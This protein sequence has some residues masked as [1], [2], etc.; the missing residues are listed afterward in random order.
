MTAND[1]LT[2][3]TYAEEIGSIENRALYCTMFPMF[4]EHGLTLTP[5]LFWKS[6]ETTYLNLAGAEGHTAIVR[7]IATR[8][9]I[10][11]FGGGFLY[12]HEFQFFDM[13]SYVA[14]I[15]S[16]FWFI[17]IQ[18]SEMTSKTYIINAPHPHC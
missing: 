2:M 11:K 5:D 9:L 8:R 10:E 4:L 7:D 14:S 17:D 16:E 6:I 12:S 15:V 3:L 13:D 18:V 1:N